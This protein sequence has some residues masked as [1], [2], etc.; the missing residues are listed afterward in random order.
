MAQSGASFCGSR[1]RQLKEAQERVILLDGILAEY[2]IR[3]CR[4]CG[5]TDDRACEGGCSWVTDAETSQGPVCSACVKSRCPDCGVDVGQ[6]HDDNCDVAR[7]L[8]TG[9][10][11]LSCAMGH[12]LRPLEPGREPL[13]PG[14]DV[15]WCS[16]FTRAADRDEPIPP[17]IS[18]LLYPA[19]IQS[20][21]DEPEPEQ[22]PISICGCDPDL[23]HDDCGDDVWTGT[24][25]GEMECAEF[26]WWVVPVG[27]QFRPMESG[28][29]SLAIPDL[30]RLA[31][32]ARWDREQA[33]FVA[34]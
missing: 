25:P 9:G 29:E 15:M 22:P 19:T 17:R 7:C 2:A 34:P 31:V 32:D 10:Q 4:V 23:L 27:G 12:G 6:A 30:N 24:W 18:C 3:Y 11:R 1:D 16:V 21:G 8:H 33:R 28:E 14:A 26:G 13:F 20:E 5:C